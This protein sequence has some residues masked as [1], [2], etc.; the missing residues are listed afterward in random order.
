MLGRLVMSAVEH[1]KTAVRPHDAVL[2][3]VVNINLGV[4]L[5]K[6]L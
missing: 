6:M 2:L 5:L 4:E 3:P 1:Q